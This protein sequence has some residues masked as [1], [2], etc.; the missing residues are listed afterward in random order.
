MVRDDQAPLKLSAP[1]AG[2]PGY[3]RLLNEFRKPQKSR[4]GWIAVVPAL[5]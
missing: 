3:T 4:D 1:P 2:P 5:A